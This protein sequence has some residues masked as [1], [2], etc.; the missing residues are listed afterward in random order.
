[1][2]MNRVEGQ[3]AFILKSQ[4]F[5]ETSVIHQLFTYEYGVVSVISKGSKAK[6]SK[7]GSILQPFRPLLASWSGKS[8]LKTLI[9][10]EQSGDQKA[11]RGHG[12]FC[13]LYVNELILSLLHKFDSHP[14][15]FNAYQKIISKLANNDMLEQNLRHF[16]MALLQ[17]VGYGVQLDVV[18]DTGCEIDPLQEYCY[19]IGQGL[20]NASFESSTLRISGSTVINLRNNTLCEKHELIQAKKLM[21]RLIDHQ[22]DGKILKSRELFL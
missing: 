5:K 6:I 22:L 4:S 13:A 18:S 11:L 12:L 10:V 9:S 2:A 21:R 8:D 20:V 15:L 19:V 14:Q 3:P 1:M 7:S 16:E 17:E